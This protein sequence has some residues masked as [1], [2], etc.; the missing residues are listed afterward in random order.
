MVKGVI[1]LILVW[2][3]SQSAGTPNSLCQNVVLFFINMPYIHKLV[4]P[5]RNM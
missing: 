4:S 1:L 3:L 2:D 5:D